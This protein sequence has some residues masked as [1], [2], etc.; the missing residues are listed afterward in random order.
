LPNYDEVMQV[1]YDE[2]GSAPSESSPILASVPLRGKRAEPGEPEDLGDE[3][4][5]EGGLVRDL[6]AEQVAYARS[7]EDRWEYLYQ[8]CIAIP[9]IA[10][11][12]LGIRTVS[13]H[14]TFFGAMAALSIVTV[15]AALLGLL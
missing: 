14:R 11:L 15:L 7:C 12:A 10:V 1:V 9:I 4:Q 3:D 5:Y 8:W 2:D 6:V 13:H